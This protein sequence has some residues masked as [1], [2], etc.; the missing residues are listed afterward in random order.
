[1]ESLRLR[2][3]IELVL[4]DSSGR[5][6]R[7]VKLGNLVVNVGKA[8]VAGL[9]NGVVSGP[10]TYVAIGDGSATSPGT[11]TSPSATDTALGHEVMRVSATVGRTTTSVT[12]D[13]ATW[14]ATF[15]FTASYSICEAGI[16][17]ASTGGT[18]LARQTFPVLNVVS[19]DRLTISWRLQVS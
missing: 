13:T 2:G 12:N 14:D 4:Y 3:E 5:V 10:F 15:T 17:D 19:G 6:K 9:I 8:K 11:C 16:F 18:M 1:M 7:R